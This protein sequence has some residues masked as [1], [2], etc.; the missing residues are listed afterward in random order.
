MRA[1]NF[2]TAEEKQ[3]IHD[4]VVAAEIKT[5]GEIVPMIVSSSA[6][7]TE[8]ELLGVI[9]GLFAGMLGEWLW[10]DPWG[11]NYF[12]LW[13]AIGAL[14]GFLICRFPAVKRR[15]ASRKRIDE[16]VDRFALASFTEEG[17]HH[18]EDHAGILILIS[19]LEHQVEIL[20]DRGIDEKVAPGTWAEIVKMLTAGVKTGRACDA[21]CQAIERCGG[22][23]ATHFP[24][25]ADDQNE[26][27]NELVTR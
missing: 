24:R 25:Q 22:I 3:R 7:Y 19:L 8:V 4:A 14:A 9:A 1:D 20:A 5:S 6:R 18:T 16:A 23:L 15:L 21:F 2:F 17:L 27:P 12:N 13:P 26:L 11:S 10:S